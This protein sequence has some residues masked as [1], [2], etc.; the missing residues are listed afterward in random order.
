[1]A[2][3][4]SRSTP[5]SEIPGAYV[6]IADS[7]GGISSEELEA[8]FDTASLRRHAARGNGGAATGLG[9]AIAKV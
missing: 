7:C 4:S 2:P 8:I 6:A 1:V 9:L 3:A 5:A